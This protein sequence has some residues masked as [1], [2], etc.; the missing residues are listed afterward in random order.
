MSL[1]L[2]SVASDVLVAVEAVSQ[3]LL[4]LL[5]RVTP[6]GV[7]EGRLAA[8]DVGLQPQDLLL[9]LGQPLLGVGDLLVELLD[10]HLLLGNDVHVLADLGHQVVDH[11]PGTGDL[12]VHRHAVGHRALHVAGRRADVAH[13]VAAEKEQRHHQRRGGR[14]NR[15]LDHGS[16]LLLQRFI[17]PGIGCDFDNSKNVLV[18]LRVTR[19]LT[20]SV[21]STRRPGDLFAAAATILRVFSK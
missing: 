1:R 15:F 3:I 20:R 13:Q 11:A 7:L 17:D 2:P 8:L 16:L 4:H 18:T 14:D 12:E 19:R 21:R 5:D 10:L 9:V 6:P